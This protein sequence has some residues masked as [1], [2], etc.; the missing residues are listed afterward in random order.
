MNKYLFFIF[1]LVLIFSSCDSKNRSVSKKENQYNIIPWPTSLVPKNGQFVINENT[2]LIANGEDVAVQIIASNFQ[3]KIKTATGYDLSMENNNA[4]KNAIIFQLDKNMEGG[5]NYSLSVTPERVSIKANQPIGLFYAVQTLRQLL[6]TEFEDQ[7]KNNNTVWSIPA[8]EMNDAPRFVYRGIHLD[9]SRH[10]FDVRTVKKII[11]QLAYHK[12]NYFHW[13]LTDDQGWR[14]EIKKYPR[15]TEIGGFRNGTLI[16]HYND[17][18]HKFDG[19]KYGGFYTQEEIKEIVQ[20]AA[21]RFITIIP[22]IELPGHAQAA[23]AAYPELGCEGDSFE[24]WQKW[25]V[26]E[27][28]FCPKEETFEF[29]ENVLDEVIELFPGKYIHIGGDECP[30]TRW[31]ESAFCQQLMRKENLKDEHELQSYFIRRIEKYINSKGRQIIGWDEIL[32]GG[33]APNATV[34]SWRG[35]EGGVEAAKSGHDVVMTPTSHCYLD[36]YQ[37]DHPEEPLA[38]GGLNPLEKIYNYEPIPDELN[39]NEAKYILG[40]QANIW[41][42]YIKTPDKLEYM[43]FPRLSALAEVAWSQKNIRNIDGFIERLSTHLNRLEK[44]GINAANHLYDL[45]SSIQPNNGKVE[46]RLNALAKAANIYYTTDGSE[47][48]INSNLYNA[49]FN[50]ESDLQLKAQS[51]LNNEKTG[52]SWT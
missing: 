22:E 18:P 20:Y 50:I 5:E 4:D 39:E 8:V 28:I 17:Q 7:T 43:L 38:I 10:F 14:I 27:N 9:V 29:L 12:L 26:S 36:Y 15:L 19:I 49:P 30:K 41:T 52:R 34:M 23:L 32:E 45:K 46:V 24:A 51:F 6:P 16:G 2:V 31:E 35:I 42:E 1:L 21:E 37:S 3:Q 33:L 40:T 44:M 13:H 48:S 47:P 11:D 25:G